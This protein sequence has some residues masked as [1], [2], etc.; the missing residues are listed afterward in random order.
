MYK[1]I[2]SKVL[3]AFLI[4]FAVPT[5]AAQ[6]EDPCT[7]EGIVVRNATMLDLWYKRNGGDCLIWIH[8]HLFTINSEDSIDIYSNM[9]CQTLYCANNPNYKDYKSFDA[10]GDCRVKILPDCNVSDM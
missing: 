3:T 4:F 2:I 10:D 8:E 7:R 5:V 1:N 9:N 6:E